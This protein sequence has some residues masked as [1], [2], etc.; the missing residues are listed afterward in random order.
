MPWTPCGSRSS[1]SAS[2]PPSRP[3]SRSRSG[4]RRSRRSRPINIPGQEKVAAELE[5]YYTAYRRLKLAMDYWCALWFW[6][7]PEAAKL[8]T[9]DEFLF[10]MELI[11]KGTIQTPQPV[12]CWGNCFPASRSTPNT[13]PSLAASGWSTSRSCWRRTSGCGSW[14][15]WRAGCGFITGSFALPT[16][17]AERGGF[18]LIVGNPPWVLVSFDEGG[19]LSDQDPVI[20]IRQMSATDTAKVRDALL[21]KEG[22]LPAYLCECEEQTGTQAYLGSLGAYPNLQGIKSNLYKC[23]ITR[24][25]D[26]GSSDGVVGLIHPE[27][28]FDDANGGKLRSSIYPRLRHHYHFRNELRL[29][30]ILNTRQFGVCV[31]GPSDDQPCQFYTIAGLFHPATIDGCHAHDGAGS[32]PG[33]KTDDN[34]WDLRPHRSRLITVGIQRLE[35]FAQ[36]YDAPRA[37][38]NQARLAVAHSEEVIRVLEKF[39]AQPRKLGSLEGVFFATQH[40]NETTAQDDGTIRRETGYPNHIDECI[41]SGPHLF[42]R[43]SVAGI[44]F[45]GVV[46][47]LH[48]MTTSTSRRSLTSTSLERTT[49]RPAR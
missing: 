32:V 17:F 19:V 46:P 43:H 5:R 40:W 36:L 24:G 8:P 39:A 41:L 12:P 11:L 25:W 42:C 37:A 16:L 15:R 34:N 4:D 23:F 1:V 33:I 9:R 18:D 38:A 20:A 31:Y 35:L 3:T 13:S 44:G 27:G 6:P 28:V 26:L 30:D 21:M 29:F 45:G 47:T 2:G 49:S 48:T 14:T 22:A 10:D 7:I